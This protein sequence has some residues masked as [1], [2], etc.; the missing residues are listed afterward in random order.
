M[1]ASPVRSPRRWVCL[2]LTVAVLVAVSS[3][4]RSLVAQSSTTYDLR[5]SPQATS[6]NLNATNYSTNTQLMVYTWPSYKV[7]NAIVMKFDLSSLPVGAAVQQAT[8]HLSLVAS[9][10]TKAATYSVSAY[11]LT[12]RNPVIASATGYTSDGVSGWKPNSC[13]WNGIPMAQADVSTAYDVE[14]ID[15]TPGFKTWTITS[16]VKEWL[17][18]PALNYGLLLDAD[19]S[20]PKDHF[21]YFASMEHPDASQHPYLDISYTLP[22]DAT[23][24]LV[25]LTAPAANSTVSGSVPV[26]ATA[27]DNVGVAGVQFKLDGQNLGAEVLTAPYSLTWDTTRMSD[28]GHT[29]TAVA[30]DAAGNTAIASL[31]VTVANNVV[32]L[33][34]QD[35]SLNLDT[36]NYSA[37][38]ELMTY[39]W[40]DYQVANAILMKF[41][42]S[43]VPAG[44]VIQQATLGLALVESDATSDTTYTV[45]ADKVTGRNPVITAATG[46]TSDGATAWTPNACCVNGVPL[47]QADISA[48]YD[49]EPIDKTAGYKTWNLTSMVQEWVSNPSTNFGVLLDSDAT[50]LHDRYRYFASMEYSDAS[51]RPYLYV[52][53][54]PAVTPVAVDTTAPSVAI[55][56]PATNATVSGTS[57]VTAA[58]SDNV[59][60][61]GVQFKLDGVNL[62]AEVLAAPYS[63]GW[64]TT[65]VAGGSHTLTA[66]ARDAAGNTTTA[67]PIAVTVANLTS[68]LWPN[69]LAG[70]PLLTDQPWDVMTGLG[71]NY[72]RRTSSIDDSIV[73]DLGAP[74]SPPN[75]LQIVFTPDMQPDSEPSVHWFSLSNVTEI[76][77]GWWM[78]L[79]PNWT[80]SP[81]GCG[82]V[83]FLFTNGAGQVYTGVYHNASGDGPPYRIAANTEWSP[84]GQQIWYP[85]VTTTPINPGEW[86]RVEVYYRW[87][88]TPGV[89]GD[90]IIRFWVDGVLNGDY[91]N[92]RYPASSFDEFQFA[93]TLQNPPPAVQYM[94]ID[95]THL[96][97]R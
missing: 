74:F 39:T 18:Q 44:A 16:I 57:T 78:K 94:F 56:A 38:G 89:S 32:W 30:R 87:E 90:G 75:E 42:L 66:V 24:P 45:S 53:Y 68:S 85:N 6:I 34:P 25:S 55:T 10:T 20:K 93:P 48:P 64:D 97:G 15:K 17:A 51:L 49:A 12:D 60:V 84:Y 96:D 37:Y 9:D 69:E 29:L 65:S 79:S 23:P 43:S 86:H 8:L 59:G 26:T 1:V 36:S 33:T 67:A 27:S 73:S 28:G 50:A 47:A 35:T 62:G 72:L 54:T 46:Y 7:A 82:K 76:Y 91:T 92:V 80:C 71:W 3:A 81:A 77:T 22:V 63:I 31:A 52:K 58:A 2:A 70:L 14:S 19:T 11:K 40:P 95:H 4:R 21:R 41:D 13:C 5:L 83:T 61:A 88:T